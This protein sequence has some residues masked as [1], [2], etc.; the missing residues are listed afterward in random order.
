MIWVLAPATLTVLALVLPAPAP[1][2]NAIAG[3]L[4]WRAAGLSVAVAAWALFT[5]A[6]WTAP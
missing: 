4:A 2:R 6:C 3:G 1:F 5:L